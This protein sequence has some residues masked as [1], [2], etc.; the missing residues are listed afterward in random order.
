MYY[1]VKL[2]TRHVSLVQCAG[3]RRTAM[4]DVRKV[5]G[6][7]WDVAAIGNGLFFYPGPVVHFFF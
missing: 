5:R 3:N 4:S 1:H 6:V 2:F 7:G